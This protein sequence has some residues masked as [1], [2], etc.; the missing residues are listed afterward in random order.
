MTEELKMAARRAYANF[1]NDDAEAVLVGDRD[2]R[3]WL[4]GYLSALR[5]RA[6][7]RLNEASR[8][9]RKRLRATWP[10]RKIN[11]I[12]VELDEVLYAKMYEGAKASGM[13]LAEYVREQ[14][15]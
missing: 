3:P 13:S 11:S 5:D 8:D 2:G 14:L 4:Q 10:P 1:F 6:N 7:P 9:G 15:K 12:R